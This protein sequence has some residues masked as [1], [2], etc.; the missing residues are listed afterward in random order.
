VLGPNADT[1][2]PQQEINKIGRTISNEDTFGGNIVSL[3]QRIAQ[4]GCFWI[5]IAA[6]KLMSILHHAAYGIRESERVDTGAEIEDAAFRHTS[7]RS[8]HNVQLQ[9]D[10]GREIWRNPVQAT[11]VAPSAISLAAPQTSPVNPPIR[12]RT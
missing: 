11:S 5:R 10:H 6:D 9:A 1:L 7:V 4:G 8:L 3:C 12:R 2:P